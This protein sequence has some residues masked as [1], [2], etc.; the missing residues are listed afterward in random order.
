MSRSRK[1]ASHREVDR[2]IRELLREIDDIKRGAIRRRG[3]FDGA[4][5]R[6]RD[7]DF[8]GPRQLSEA[9]RRIEHVDRFARWLCGK[10]NTWPRSIQ[11]HWGLPCLPVDVE[12]ELSKIWESFPLPRLR[13]AIAANLRLNLPGW[14]RAPRP[15]IL[16]T[17]RKPRRFVAPSQI[18]LGPPGPEVPPSGLPLLEDDDVLEG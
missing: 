1:R 10:L 13:E 17:R 18:G 14:E 9:P 4:P 3:T 2:K 15:R 16:K 5:G 7:A 12:R 6:A 8:P 11:G